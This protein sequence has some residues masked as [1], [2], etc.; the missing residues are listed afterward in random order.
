LTKTSS[1]G[2]YQKISPKHRATAHSCDHLPKTFTKTSSNGAF[3]RP[4]KQRRIPA[5][6][7]KNLTKASS[8]GAFL[9]PL[10]KKFHQNIEQRHHLLE[11]FSKLGN[12]VRIFSDVDQEKNRLR[13]N[14][15]TLQIVLA[16]YNLDNIWKTIKKQNKLTIRAKM[17]SGANGSKKTIRRR[18]DILFW[19]LLSS[20][21]LFIWHSF[22]I[23]VF[24]ST[25]QR[26]HQSV[27]GIR[28]LR[29]TLQQIPD[30]S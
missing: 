4:L 17:T 6:I 11:P 5:T 26:S 24:A 29:Q 10:T 25:M 15:E 19:R 1:N 28:H 8:N 18:E 30:I 3:L 23:L 21:H 2:T 14:S 20:G 13:W 22:R 9:R 12:S 7:P 16:A 27:H